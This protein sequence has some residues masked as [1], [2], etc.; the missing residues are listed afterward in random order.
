VHSV[1]LLLDVARRCK[2]RVAYN[3]KIAS[4]ASK[5]ISMRMEGDMAKE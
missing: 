2:I 4:H 5:S 1:N 3:Y